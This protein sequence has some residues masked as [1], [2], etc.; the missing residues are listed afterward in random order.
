MLRH[1]RSPE[2]EVEVVVS[3]VL[4]AQR[5]RLR[6]EQVVERRL[7]RPPP[8]SRKLERGERVVVGVPQQSTR[9]YGRDRCV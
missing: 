9:G 4:E 5:R 7:D 8:P 2:S 3:A 1:A 6:R